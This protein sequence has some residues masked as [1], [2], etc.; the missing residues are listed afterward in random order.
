M[1]VKNGGYKN[2]IEC[3]K[4]FY[5]RR[6]RLVSAKWCSQECWAKRGI[7]YYQRTCPNCTIQFET[8]DKRQNYCSKDC[9]LSVH[10]GNKS[11][12]W[13]GGLT[14]K[15]KIER[16]CAK[17]RHWRLEVFKRDNFTC[18]ECGKRDRTIEADH[19]KPQSEYPEL[20]Y[21]LSNGRT[22]C[23]D[24]HKETDTYGYKQRWE[25]FTEKKAVKIGAPVV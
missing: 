24:C 19:I 14:E 3:G 18:V 2:C 10:L 1:S 7:T 4:K 15:S 21:E 22:L 20:R 11:H 23:H 5:V 6:D 9:S 13:K 25:K 16:T 8:V 17:Y 12:L